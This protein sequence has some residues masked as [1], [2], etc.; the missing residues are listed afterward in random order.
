MSPSGNR[1]GRT[2][3]PGDGADMTIK[4]V[5]ETIDRRNPLYIYPV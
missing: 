4:G 3:P 5:A 1:R 2:A